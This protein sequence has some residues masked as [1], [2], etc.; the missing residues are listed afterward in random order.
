MYLQHCILHIY[1][2]IGDFTQYMFINQLCPVV[3]GHEYFYNYYNNLV[4][5]IIKLVSTLNNKAD[6]NY[7]KTILALLLCPW[8]GLIIR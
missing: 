3:T 8:F 1:Y 4:N 2:Y 6:D 7:F 5:M